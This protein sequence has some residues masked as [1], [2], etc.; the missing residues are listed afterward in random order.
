MTDEDL[1]TPHP[2]F[3]AHFTDPLYDDDGDDDTPFGSDEGYELLHEAA[4]RRDAIAASPTLATVLECEPHHVATYMGP[5]VG[6]DGMDTA[7]FV[8]SGAFTVLRLAGHLPDADRDLALAAIDLTL[9]HIARMNPD[10]D[11]PPA[12][13]VTARSDLATW[14]NPTG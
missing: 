5:M 11:R 10:L 4:G 13:W 6:S 14:T 8:I 2:A 12:T 9:A 1:P 7:S 3:A